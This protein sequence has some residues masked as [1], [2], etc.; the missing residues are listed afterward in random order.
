MLKYIFEDCHK[1]IMINRRSTLTDSQLENCFGIYI[2]TYNY[3]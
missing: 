3:K 2:F 1:L